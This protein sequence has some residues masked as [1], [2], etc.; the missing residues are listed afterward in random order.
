MF[1]IEAMVEKLVEHSKI[2][3]VKVR[4]MISE[5]KDELSGLVSEE[6]AAYIVARELGLNMI[7]E[8]RKQL[9]VKNLVSG[10]RSVD[11]VARIMTTYDERTFERDGKQG[12]V[13]NILLGD[14]T[15]AVRM[16]LWNQE[17]ELV[18]QGKIKEGDTVK[19]SGGWVKQ[20]NRD[21]LELRLGRG[22][23]QKVDQVVELPDKKQMEQSY[24]SVKRSEISGFK[25]GGQYQVRAAFLQVFRRNPF[26][27]VC[28][29]CKSRVRETD[30]KWMCE[31]HKDV[32]PEFALVMSGILDDGTENIRAVFFREAAERMFGKS[33]QELRDVSTKADDSLAVFEDVEAF[34][35]EYLFTGR[36]KMNSFSESLE[37]IVNSI[38]DVDVKKE[39]EELLK[40]LN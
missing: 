38:E 29:E 21:A 4:G 5:K 40:Q 28:P 35:K 39:S 15:G 2:D 11:L 30:G 34:G 31:D 37:F 1:S 32:S 36:V 27:A 20:D 18:K 26:F 12:S 19:I 10:L 8:T 23:I 3:P 17:T 14:E 6:G 33:T 25:E 24:Q 9:K 16:S 22:S 7:R 13:L